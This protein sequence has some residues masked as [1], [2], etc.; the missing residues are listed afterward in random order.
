MSVGSGLRLPLPLVAR[1][2]LDQSGARRFKQDRPRP[3]S[4]V[5]V[6][7]PRDLSDHLLLRFRQGNAQVNR[8]AFALVFPWSCY[9]EI[10]AKVIHTIYC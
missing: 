3:R 4:H 8:L 1:S 9:D 2:R 7:Q 5:H 6:I 10:L